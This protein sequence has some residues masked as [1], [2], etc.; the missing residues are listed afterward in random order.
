MPT[1]RI[2]RSPDPDDA[3]MYYAMISGKVRMEGYDLEF[4]TEDIESLNRRAEK[5]ELDVTAISASAYANVHDKYYVMRA[6]SSLGDGYGP[7]V[8]AKYPC[9]MEELK[10][11]SIAIPGMRTTAYLLLRMA[12]GNLRVT[13]MHFSTIMTAV[14]EG[15]VDAGLII[16]EGQLTYR[17]YG[18]VKVL[19][20][21]EW[22]RAETGDEAL[23]L[24]LD[25][26]KKEH[27]RE[28]AERFC[29]LLRDS[30]D[31]ALAH[32]EAM[33][34]AMQYSRGAPREVVERFVRMYVNDLTRDLK[35]R[36]V[37][38]L[39]ILYQRAASAGLIKPVSF[40]LV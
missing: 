14:Q 6:G 30:I 25:V 21:G 27:G 3:F 13:E 31:Y 33:D 23:P 37:S 39:R 36:G 7:I 19:D 10:K 2:G 32:K 18:L 28:Y 9:D 34:F 17:Q 22:W 8:V 16:H 15:S 38:G 12:L 26:V 5:A 11:M 35:G 24:G 29:S 4:V 1:I 20:L 40:E